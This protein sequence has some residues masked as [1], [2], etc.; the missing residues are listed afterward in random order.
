LA[1]KH[2]QS[3]GDTF[4]AILG[5]DF[6]NFPCKILEHLILSV[7]DHFSRLG[8]LKEAQDTAK[9][10]GFLLNLLLYFIFILVAIFSKNK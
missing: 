10:Y 6:E 1:F 5:S 9:F 4:E 7:Y 3:I 8:N 2:A